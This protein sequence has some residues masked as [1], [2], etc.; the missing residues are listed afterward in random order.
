VVLSHHVFCWDLNSGPSEEQSVLL[1][2]EPSSPLKF[3][4]NYELNHMNTVILPFI[5]KTPES[6]LK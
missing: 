1:P 5:A 6:T 4:L 2:V 3:F